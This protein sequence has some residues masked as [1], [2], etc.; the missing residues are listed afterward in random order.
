MP[1]DDALRDRLE[2]LVPELDDPAAVVAAIEQRRAAVGTGR[3]RSR[4][5]VAASIAL[6][7]AVA[8]AAVWMSVDREPTGPAGTT[9]EPVRIL[10]GDPPE[11][12]VVVRVDDLPYV[13]AGDESWG[14]RHPVGTSPA[15]AQYTVAYR[16]AEPGDLARGFELEVLVG[17]ELDVEALEADLVGFDHFVVERISVGGR[18]GVVAWDPDPRYSSDVV[19]IE[20]DQAVVRL[21]IR[22][23]DRSSV[24]AVAAGV[25]VASAG[26]WE[27][28]IADADVAPPY[29]FV[30]ETVLIAAGDRW[31]VVGGT[32][33]G[34]FKD[35]DTCA[36]LQHVTAPSDAEMFVDPRVCAEWID[37]SQPVWLEHVRA[38]EVTILWGLAAEEVARVVLIYDGGVELDV[39]LGAEGPIRSE[40]LPDRSWGIAGEVG[41][42]EL[43]TQLVAF[44]ADGNELQNEADISPSR[45]VPPLV[46]DD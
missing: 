14:P 10:T 1:V 17:S 35:R 9:G 41:A 33:R 21:D 2:R 6:L 11:G 29:G 5:L 13:P 46:F 12:F 39:E 23:F 34:M 43:P 36:E 7:A 26:E 40:R 38:D 22:G 20:L 30:G 25:R 45:R 8:L 16:E 27:R 37:A 24:L 19:W 4:T 15:T 3:R 42:D 28:A 31:E 44:D 18:T 32:Y